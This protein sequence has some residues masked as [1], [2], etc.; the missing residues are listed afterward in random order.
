MNSYSDGP[1]GGCTA[2][3]QINR[4]KMLLRGVEPSTEHEPST[5]LLHYASVVDIAKI[6]SY[7][8]QK[9]HSKYQVRSNR[10]IISCGRTKCASGAVILFLASRVRPPS[11]IASNQLLALHPKSKSRRIAWWR[12]A[13]LR[14][15]ELRRVTAGTRA[16]QSRI[17]SRRS[18]TGPP[19]SV[20][21]AR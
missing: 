10:V 4:Q 1:C 8:F 16:S 6:G 5:E 14:G 13:V 17:G 15:R 9:Y 19:S 12:Q 11:R 2:L 20:R 7:L 3:A 18:V 21:V